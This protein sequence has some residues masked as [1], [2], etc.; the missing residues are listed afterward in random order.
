M[1]E[2]LSIEDLSDVVLDVIAGYECNV[3][4]DY[5]TVSDEM[6]PH[7]MPTRKVL[8]EIMLARRQ[9]VHK[10]SFGGGEP[11]IRRDLLPIVAWCR[12][13][14][15]D[16]VKV[17]SN[18]LMYSYEDYAKRAVE[19]GIT[20]F[21]VSIMGHD[22]SLYSEI[23]RMPEAFELVRK[24]VENL[25]NLGASPVADLIVKNNTYRHLPD[26]VEFW[27]GL[28]IERFVLWL[29]SLTDGNKD[30]LE[31]LPRVSVMAPWIKRAFDVGE[32]LGVRVE[33]RHI[34]RCMLKGH[35]RFV[36]DLRQDRVIVVTPSSRFRLW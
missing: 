29:V 24:G 20:D 7:N 14:G 25:V 2:H 26:I 16:Y 22:E 4:C 12:D 5:C 18:G 17:S 13:R 10:V 1:T 34:P 3:K 35:E 21:H 31:S 19:S 33:S 15:F 8:A 23:M 9:G 11:T 28:G 6:R 32:G 27:A 36:R 30:N